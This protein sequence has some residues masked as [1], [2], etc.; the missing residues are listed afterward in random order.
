MT[1]D[2]ISVCIL[3]DSCWFKSFL[4]GIGNSG[5]DIAVE[6]SRHAS[7]VYLSTRRGAW[8]LSRLGDDGRPLDYFTTRFNSL[9]PKVLLKA[10][11]KAKLNAKFN[12]ANFGL[13]PTHSI[14]GQ[15]PMVNDDLPHRIITGAIV[16][17]PNVSHFTETGVFFEDNSSVQDLDAVIFCTGYKFGFSFVNQSLIPVKD[18]E[19]SLYKYIFPPD[20]PKGTLA[21]IGCFQPLGALMPLSE[22][23]A[24]WATRVFKGVAKL[25]SEK[26]MRGDIACKKDAMRRKYYASKRHTIQVSWVGSLQD[27]GDVST[28]PSLRPNLSPNPAPNQTLNLTRACPQKPGSIRRVLQLQLYSLYSKKSELVFA[29]SRK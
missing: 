24:R 2:A 5:G 28:H 16:I 6:L 9:I 14:L 23:Q 17:K 26:A 1:S 27:S 7:K 11:F 12:H 20:L 18:N 22:L 19:V 13:Q 8:V 29:L 4:T 21:V 15:H 10:A 3:C 25:P